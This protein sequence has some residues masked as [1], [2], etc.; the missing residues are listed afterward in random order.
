MK[1]VVQGQVGEC[2]GN[3]IG[4][5]QLPRGLPGSLPTV[6]KQLKQ[7]IKVTTLYIQDGLRMDTDLSVL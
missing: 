5:T 3:T 7:Q 1:L 4:M 6:S 2:R